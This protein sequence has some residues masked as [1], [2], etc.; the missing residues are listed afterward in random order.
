[1]KK[2]LLLL[3]APVLALLFFSIHGE[4]RLYAQTASGESVEIA[5]QGDEGDSEKEKKD[6]K[7]YFEELF[8]YFE[9][10]ATSFEP[11]AGVFLLILG[12]CLVLVGIGAVTA[13]SLFAVGGF[14]LLLGVVTISLIVGLAR[15]RPWAA[16][17]ALTVQV[18]AVAGGLCGVAVCWLLAL[19]AAGGAD[20]AAVA[21]KGVLLGLPIGVVIALFFNFA[22][23]R[24]YLL[25]KKTYGPEP[26]SLPR[27]KAPAPRRTGTTS[28]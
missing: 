22:C 5:S 25:I 26:G 20:F 14:L 16:V 4:N 11:G 7:D 27:A 17:R 13:L 8:H 23:A 2:T 3:T 10:E 28:P 12:A 1:M 21:T 9:D 18:A 15:K 19:S 6:L 24:M